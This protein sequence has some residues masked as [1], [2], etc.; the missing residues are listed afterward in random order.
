[1]IT[2]ATL[3][4]WFAHWHKVDMSFACSTKENNRIAT[5]KT[6]SAV[7]SFALALCAAEVFA[8]NTHT[9]TFRRM[10]G[11]VLQTVEVAHGANATSLA[12]ESALPD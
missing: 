6:N 4:W 9:V 5:M 10:N 3:T 11:T 1:M 2:F 12:P 8:A 7:I